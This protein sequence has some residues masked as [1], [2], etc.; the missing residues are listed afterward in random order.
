LRGISTLRVL[1]CLASIRYGT[2]I[3][4]LR[5]EGDKVI[6]GDPAEAI[7]DAHAGR[8]FHVMLAP[9]HFGLLEGKEKLFEDGPGILWRELNI[10]RPVAEA[11]ERKLFRITRKL[12]VS[13]RSRRW[14]KHMVLAWHE[15]DGGNLEGAADLAACAK[16]LPYFRDV[17]RPFACLHIRSC[18]QESFKEVTAPDLKRIFVPFF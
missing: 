14:L 17:M 7:R 9:E 2:E 15:C 3:T 4:V 16:E 12:S 11:I 1:E 10:F 18:A 8:G 6:L 5:R 13:H